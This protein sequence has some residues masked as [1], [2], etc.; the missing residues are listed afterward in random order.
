MISYNSQSATD[1]DVPW[2]DINGPNASSQGMSWQHA[3]VPT[4]Q[5]AWLSG[6]LADASKAGQRVIVFVHYRLDGGLPGAP[7]RIDDCTLQNVADVR[8]ILESEPGLVLATFSG[9]DH[10]AKPSYTHMGDGKPV[11]VTLNAMVEGA[12]ADGHNAYSVVSILSDCSVVVQGWGDQ[13]SI[14]VEG[15][16]GCAFEVGTSVV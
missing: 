7:S 5:L 14:T 4:A 3:N 1:Q 2:A 10:P 6:E 13:P 16:S 11:Y 9:H 15:P 8:T 12:Y